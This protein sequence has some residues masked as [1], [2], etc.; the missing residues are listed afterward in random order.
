MCFALLW[1]RLVKNVAVFLPTV[2]GALIFACPMRCALATWCCLRWVAS[3]A[4]ATQTRRV[5]HVSSFSRRPW[6]KFWVSQVSINLSP[7]S[8]SWGTFLKLSFSMRA[9]LLGFHRRA[10]H[11]VKGL[12]SQTHYAGYAARSVGCVGVFCCAAVAPPL[13]CVRQWPCVSF[14][15]AGASKFRIFLPLH[16]HPVLLI[17]GVILVVSCL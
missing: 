6:F 17:E 4:V 13:V 7:R 2:G 11:M 9:D 12:I 3:R 14:L 8:H 1:L 15:F 5:G 10:R 16:S